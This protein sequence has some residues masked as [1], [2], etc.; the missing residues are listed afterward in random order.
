[1]KTP[2]ILLVDDSKA[3]RAIVAK[4][5]NGYDCEILEA[6]NGALGLDVARDNHPDLIVL[7]MTMPVMNGV[8]TLQAL[9]ADETLK[10]I[11]V[12]MLTANSNP[13]EM[14]QMKALGATDYVTK[15]QKPRVILDRAIALIGL[16]A[17]P[18]TVVAT[19]ST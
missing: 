4:M 11:P 3:T 15:T 18:G 8:E 13:E 6:A 9:Q 7:D 2:R 19:V 5:L 14:E 10:I 17:K 12:I 16:Q 1:M